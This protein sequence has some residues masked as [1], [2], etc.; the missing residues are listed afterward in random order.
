MPTTYAVTTEDGTYHV[1]TEDEP[2]Q[3]AG[4]APVPQESLLSTVGKAARQG[5]VA[6]MFPPAADYNF[7]KSLSD[8]V[9]EIGGNFAHPANASASLTAGLRT[10]E[11]VPGPWPVRALAGLAAAGAPYL[12][13]EHL[14]NKATGQPDDIGKSAANFGI[15]A[16]LEG[17]GSGVQR[18]VKALKGKLPLAPGAEALSK[19]EP[20]VSQYMQEAGSKLAPIA[21]TFEDFFAPGGKQAA[22]GRSGQ[23]ADQTITGQA[24]GMA[25]RSSAEIANPVAHTASI[26]H[27]DIKPAFDSTFKE[28]DKQAT[29][30]KTIAQSNTVAIPSTNNFGMPTVKQV[31]GPI[32]LK[33]TLT[34]ANKIVEDTKDLQ[35]GL[36][37]DQKAIVNQAY[38]LI[39][40]TNATFDD[41]G[42]L[43]RADPVPFSETWD[44]KKAL[45]DLGG[46]G[47]GRNDLSNTERQFR[48]FASTINAD[49]DNSIGRWPNDPNK[50][51]AKA[52]ENS[53]GTVAQRNALFAPEGSS[54]KLS[55][56]LNESDSPLPAVRAIVNDPIQLQRALNIS[57]I[58]FPSGTVS[59]NNMR[60]DLQGFTLQ[61][62]MNTAKEKD[63]LDPSK[64]TINAKQLYN[65]W[66]NPTSP[67]NTSKLFSG[68]QI[69][70]IDQ[71]LKNIAVTQ[72]QPAGMGKYLQK[73]WVARAGLALAPALV[74]I[75]TG[76]AEHALTT[77]GV[78]LSGHY[79]AKAMVN[80]KIAKGLIA[81]S[82]G[83][84]LG[85]SEQ[86]F[87]KLLATATQGSAVTL[88]KSDGSREKGTLDGEGTFT[89]IQ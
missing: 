46:W 47:K 12:A 25:G 64:L 19:L 89:P 60:R 26:V 23:L 34:A 36:P 84:P 38:K 14:I 57:K 9:K 44:L 33:D 40:S 45:N 3:P 22:V 66:D 30:A 10:A 11:M 74:G 48:Q 88:L 20:T 27:E 28:A 50:M 58:T 17:A 15:N 54:N 56:I 62:I 87:S 2:S 76:S 71:L 1:T 16:L 65:L 43:L 75:G 42:Q 13:G 81:I 37:E 51:A 39:H 18:A 85:M 68:A 41:T 72:Q 77:L 67:R 7:D 31:A 52:W 24:A 69:E 49:I 6:G 83:Q 70:D 35:L 8:N 63:Q 73:I 82:S 4:P 78:E 86:L 80:P 32:Q 21:K 53:K 59:S 29:L 61:D 79:L 55:D 5:L